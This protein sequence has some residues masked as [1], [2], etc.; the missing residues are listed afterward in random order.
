MTSVNVVMFHSP[1]NVVCSDTECIQR[2]NGF[3]FHFNDKVNPVQSNT[4][5]SNNSSA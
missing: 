3:V 1:V 4:H 2:I 5:N